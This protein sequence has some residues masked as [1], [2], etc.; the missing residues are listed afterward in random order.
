MCA[1]LKQRQVDGAYGTH[2]RT[3]GDATAAVLQLS[4]VVFQGSNG[5]IPDTRINVAFFLAGKERRTMGS[6]TKCEC[7]GLVDGN[8]NR[9][10]RVRLV[11]GMNQFAVN[12]QVFRVHEFSFWLPARHRVDASNRPSRISGKPI[13]I[14]HKSLANS[15]SE[16]NLR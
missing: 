6:I 12:T 3:G 7:R 11:P 13:S 14:T 16:H 1:C 2:A 4:D 15:D 8:I 9:T 5:G 10:S